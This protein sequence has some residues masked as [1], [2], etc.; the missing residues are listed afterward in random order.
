MSIGWHCGS[1]V[2]CGA[3]C[4][5][6]LSLS[7]GNELGH[8]HTAASCPCSPLPPLSAPPP[9]AAARGSLAFLQTRRGLRKA[10]GLG[11]VGWGRWAGV[12]QDAQLEKAR[13]EGDGLDRVEK[14]QLSEPKADATARLRAAQADQ[15][16]D[17]LEGQPAKPRPH[18]GLASL[19]HQLTFGAST[20]HHAGH[21]GETRGQPA[22]RLFDSSSRAAA[23]GSCRRG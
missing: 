15:V 17:R 19:A 12:A 23:A 6:S 16:V 1:V 11:W 21:D 2:R 14:W 22:A 4:P 10:R 18:R 20:H 13:T 5:H 8:G 7:L 9:A 3:R